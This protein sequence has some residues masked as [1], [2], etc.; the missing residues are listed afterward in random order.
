[1]A[2][3]GGT[4]SC[5]QPGELGSG[6]SPSPASDEN[7][8]RLTADSVTSVPKRVRSLGTGTHCSCPQ[9]SRPRQ[10]QT[11]KQT[12]TTHV[13]L[14]D[15]G[16]WDA[17]RGVRTG[18]PGGGQEGSLPNRAAPGLQRARPGESESEGFSGLAAARD[19]PGA[20]TP[21]RNEHVGPRVQGDRAGAG[22]RGTRQ[23]EALHPSFPR[24]FRP[25]GWG[26]GGGATILRELRGFTFLCPHRS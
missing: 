18:I 14:D 11:G 9:G 13:A 21:L 1:M 3:D 22:L 5:Q 17:A 26:F 24:P 4:G 16:W 15:G 19:S 7:T 6:S 12:M 8:A 20:R 2:R 23:G 10:K 25:E